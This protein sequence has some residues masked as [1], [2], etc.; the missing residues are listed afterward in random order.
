[1]GDTA[2]PDEIVSQILTPAL[3]VSDD[4]FSDTSPTTFASYNHST[5]AYLVVCKSWLR[6]ATPLLYNVVIL[7][8]TAQA[9]ALAG[10]L[11]RNKDLGR[12]IKKLRVEGGYGLA[13][14]TVLELAP[15]I[16]DL[17]LSLEIW[18]PD[19]TEGL[20][21]GLSLINPT[22]LI[23]RDSQ[24]GPTNSMV[25][26]LVNSLAAVIPKW[27]KLTIFDCPHA[28][29][30]TW[31]GLKYKVATALANS[32]RLEEI[33]VEDVSVVLTIHAIFQSCPLRIILVK[34]RPGPSNYHIHNRLNIELPPGLLTYRRL[35]QPAGKTVTEPTIIARASNPS[36]IPL[37]N[38]SS[39]VQEL[40]WSRVLFFAMCC[41]ERADYLRA[42]GEYDWEISGSR[43]P[44][45][46]VCKRFLRVGLPHFYALVAPKRD[47]YKTIISTFKQNPALKRPIQVWIGRP[48]VY[49]PVRFFDDLAQS[50]CAS[51]VHI[52]IGVEQDIGEVVLPRTFSHLRVLRKLE[53]TGNVS[54]LTEEEGEV[55]T[56]ALPQLQELV[57]QCAT[58][59][60]ITVLTRM[61][62]PSLHTLYVDLW[63]GPEVGSSATRKLRSARLTVA[64]NVQALLEAHGTKLEKLSLSINALTGVTGKVL[65][66]CPGLTTLSIEAGYHSPPS[67]DVFTAQAP[68]TSITKLVLDVDFWFSTTKK[69]TAQ[70]EK[71]LIQFNPHHSLPNLR[72]ICFTSCEWPRTERDI[73]KS[74]W[75]RWSEIL[76]NL[77]IDLVDNSGQKWRPRLKLAAGR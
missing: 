68:H 15:H 49:F 76:L 14:H 60:F 77:N 63:T 56:D 2:L 53:W 71:F 34:Q 28:Y 22:R 21:K 35:P 10:V 32:R 7:R 48:T 1:M 39:L 61:K 57:V 13:M 11:R 52:R 31:Q 37:E 75:V 29:L 41:S 62:L 9:T 42:H 12:F 67:Q 4:A 44:F 69:D 26:A 55:D 58:P 45:L 24:S 50:S 36:F 40:V 17:F 43:L 65:D 18:S 6:V 72:E 64:G 47:C 38:E 73:V 74:C 16:T 27:D 8:S 54:F 25:I 30:Y 23:L 70:W 33:V 66:L 46:L 51:L 5:S 19:N 59:S 3:I 20:C